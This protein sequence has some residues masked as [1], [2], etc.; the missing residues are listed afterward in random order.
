MASRRSGCQAMSSIFTGVATQYHADAAGQQH[1]IA[2][3][4]AAVSKYKDHLPLHR[5]SGIYERSG[6]ALKA[7]TLG[8]WVAAGTDGLG[9]IAPG[10][11]G[12]RRSTLTCSRATLGLIRRSR[13]VEAT[14]R[15][16]TYRPARRSST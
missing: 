4:A 8:D 10:R 6:V 3:A 5:L 15:P 7:S 12:G 1:Q 16:K 11:S 9:P 13:A 14:A 2:A